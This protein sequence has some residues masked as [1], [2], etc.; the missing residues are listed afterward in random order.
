MESPAAMTNDVLIDV[1]I[2][3]YNAE[4]TIA[5]AVGSI[6][7]QSVE[8]IRVVVVDDG[9]TDRTGQI[10]QQIARDDPRV[11]VLTKANGGVVEAL[12]YG[13]KHCSAEFIARHDADDVAFPSRFSEQ[14]AHLRSNPDCVAVGCNVRHIDQN[15]TRTGGRSEFSGDVAPDPCSAPSQEPYLLHPFL[16]AR[17]AAISVVGGYRFVFHSEDTDLYWRLLPFGRLHNLTDI[18]GEYRIHQGSVSS[19]SILNGRI[20]AVSSQ[21]AAISYGRREQGKPD[22]E[23]ER[24]MLRAY[25]DAGSLAGIVELAASQLDPHEKAYLEIATSAK[26]LYLLTY[27]PYRIDVGD[28]RFIRRAIERHASTLTADN[29]RALQRFQADAIIK[30]G[31]SGRVREILALAPSPKVLARAPIRMVKLQGRRL[32][33]RQR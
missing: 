26:L 24:D 8:N 25:Q 13:L 19:A 17:R 11:E 1:L 28:C 5:E 14:L 20:A 33:N 29:R 4:A 16:M 23:F 18:L 12:N 9:S 15:G 6:Q 2:P 21:L 30:L 10:L 31:R 3:A 27:R 22:I 32:A 7:G